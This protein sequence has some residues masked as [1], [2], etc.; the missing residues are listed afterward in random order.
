MKDIREKDIIEIEFTKMTT[1]NIYADINE[2]NNNIKKWGYRCLDDK[3]KNAKTKL[4]LIDK[5]GYKYYVTY[6]SLKSTGGGS[7]FVSKY[8]KYS[9]ENIRLWLIK[10]DLPYE[11]LSDVF[12]KNNKKLKF[13]C[14]KHNIDFEI[15]WN[16]IKFGQHCYLCGEEIRLKKSEAYK[17]NIDI[18]SDRVSKKSLP[19]K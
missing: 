1:E 4:N 10:K 11:L 12:E 6:D 8:N 19:S 14:N 9:I 7:D 18:A 5:D 15:N 16:N 13:H 2:I 17:L 3:Y